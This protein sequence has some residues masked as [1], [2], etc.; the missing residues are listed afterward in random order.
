MRGMGLKRSLVIGASGQVG[1]QL[2]EV[3]DQENPGRALLSSRTPREGWFDLDLAI[4]ADVKKRF[5]PL[6]AIDLE[7]IYCLGSMTNVDSCEAGAEIAMRSNAESPALLAAYAHGRDI[8][9]VYISTEYVFQAR[10]S[11]LGR[12]GRK[13]RPTR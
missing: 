3:L 2:L 4:P 1:T 10:S 11:T 6:N 12:T 7:A 8:P 13:R 9:F 5:E